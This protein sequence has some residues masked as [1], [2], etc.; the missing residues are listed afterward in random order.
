MR[1]L[2][3]E[4]RHKPN[5]LSAKCRPG[6][7]IPVDSGAYPDA[8]DPALLGS[9]SAVVKAGGRYVWDDV[10]EISRL[11]PPQSV[12]RPTWRMEMTIITSS[13]PWPRHSDFPKQPRPP[14]VW[15]ESRTVATIQ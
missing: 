2:S 12:V 14:Q 10:L 15:A 13:R 7:N 8:V 5:W 4:L 9:Y 11:V 3:D 6:L 1:Y